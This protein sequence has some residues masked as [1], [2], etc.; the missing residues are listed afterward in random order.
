MPDSK[1]RHSIGFEPPTHTVGGWRPDRAQTL[2]LHAA[3]LPDDRALASFKRWL[4]HNETHP[5]DSASWRLLPLL[6]DNLRELDQTHP[7]LDEIAPIVRY[8]WLRNKIHLNRAAQVLEMLHARGV[9]TLMLKG[10]PLLLR[11]Y[12]HLGLRS[13]EDFDILIPTDQAEATIAFLIKSGWTPLFIQSELTPEWIRSH[14][15]L[16]FVD[17]DETR[18]DLHWHIFPEHVAPDADAPFWDASV[19]FDLHGVATRALDATDELLAACLNGLRWEKV[20]PIRWIGDAMMI[21]ESGEA[22]DWDRLLAR[23]KDL[24][25]L[26]AV[27]VALTS[28]RF[29]FTA[30]IPDETIREINAQRP[31]ARDSFDFLR[32]I[33]PP[34]R[35]TI[36]QRSRLH[37]QRFLMLRE[38][39][40]ELLR[41]P[42]FPRYL[43]RE[44]RLS[45]WLHAPFAAVRKLSSTLARRLRAKSKANSA[46]KTP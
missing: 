46:N 4:T 44:W 33:H 43:Q 18:L 15:S 42:G 20:P 14:H 39:D 2:L 5:I 37:W 30:A 19:E 11:Y 3:L 40:A 31:T 17:D 10:S 1:K 6:R 13:M 28:L 22:I 36:A 41:F 23:A 32:R 12:T 16:N 21:L 34:D 8:T 38:H 29:D 45:S 26:S 24:G 25:Q 9:K 27:R 35:A 7:A